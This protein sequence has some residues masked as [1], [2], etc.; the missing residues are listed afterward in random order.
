MYVTQA[1]CVDHHIAHIETDTAV[2]DE[3]RLV[4]EIRQVIAGFEGITD[5]K[6]KCHPIVSL[7]E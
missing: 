7:S 5:I 3:E 6:I 4:K 2:R 1:V